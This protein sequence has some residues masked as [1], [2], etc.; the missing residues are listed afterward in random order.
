V[1]LSHDFWRRHFDNDPQVTSKTLS[2]GGR[3]YHIV[4]VAPPGFRGL[5]HLYAADV[6]VPMA[7]APNL[8]PLPKFIEERR[9]LMFLMAGRLLP[10]IGMAQAEA[11]LQTTAAELERQY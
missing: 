6:W 5:H 7:M 2:L 11:G 1:V 10:G 4:G 3:A 9:A 8:F